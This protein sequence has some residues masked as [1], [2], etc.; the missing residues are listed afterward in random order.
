MPRAESQKAM[1]QAALRR[2]ELI[3]L[4]VSDRRVRGSGL[5]FPL[6][7]AHLDDELVVGAGSVRC[8]LGAR[9]LLPLKPVFTRRFWR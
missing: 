1:R 8:R 2:C 4:A 6:H 9:L 3:S 5:R 7:V